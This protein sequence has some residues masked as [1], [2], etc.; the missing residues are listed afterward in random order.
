MNTFAELLRAI[1]LEVSYAR[2]C[3]RERHLW[4][5]RSS[6]KPLVLPDRGAHAASF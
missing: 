6:M 2:E 4:L 3:R 1:A 5:R